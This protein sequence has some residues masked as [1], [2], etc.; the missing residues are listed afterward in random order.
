MLKIYELLSLYAM[1]WSF[2]T[3]VIIHW[4]I[5]IKLH[6]ATKNYK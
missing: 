6:K 5:V 3:L 2:V 4:I 1:F